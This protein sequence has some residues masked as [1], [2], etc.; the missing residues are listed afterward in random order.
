MKH[1]TGRRAEGGINLS[2]H[3]NFYDVLLI[4]GFIISVTGFALTIYFCSMPV[5]MVRESNFLIAGLLSYG[6]RVAL[7]IYGI[8]WSGIFII[9]SYL[10]DRQRWYAKEVAIVLF[11]MPVFNFVHDVAVII[12]V[13]V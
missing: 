7:T 3:L 13:G 8:F 9:Y 11:V 12:G 4:A 10:R 6:G 5:P 1:I 2:P